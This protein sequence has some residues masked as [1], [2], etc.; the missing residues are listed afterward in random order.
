MSFPVDVVLQDAA[1]SLAANRMVVLQAPPGSGKTTRAAPYLLSAPWLQG[2]K[3]LLLEP[4]RLAA[5]SAAS[6]MARQCGER[7][8]QTIGY[9]IRLENRTTSET[10]IEILTEG[11]LA[12]RLL[13][14]PE[15]SDAGLVIFDEFH[16][17]NLPADFSLALAL[18]SRSALRPDLRI[19]VM[20]A[21]LDAEPIAV[22]LGEADVITALGKMFPVETRYLRK[23][24][25]SPIFVTVAD[26]VCRAVAEERGSVL[27][28][29]PGEGEIRSTVEELGN[30]RLPDDVSVHPLYGALNRAD[31]DRAIEPA[32]SGKRKVVLATAIAESSLT[33]E[34]IRVVIDSGWMRVPR[35]SPRNGMS[36]LET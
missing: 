15:L 13:S 28:F 4:R 16:E 20:S 8:G 22:Y 9:R 25:T 30:R 1:N 21:T 6:F 33:I 36:R 10:R 34:G 3:I 19:M 26:A 35:F 2:K 17:R 5:R 23:N 24:P 27:A 31:Q 7:V 29:L 14:D 18:D 11:L 32:A 12:Q